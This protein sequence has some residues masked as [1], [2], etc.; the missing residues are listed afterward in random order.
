[1]QNIEYPYKSY[2][3]DTISYNT[4]KIKKKTYTLSNVNYHILN[5]D[6]SVITFDD[7]ISSLY[8]S[9]ILDDD[10]NI[11]CFSPPNSIPFDKFQELN[12][13]VSVFANEIVEGTMINLFYDPRIQSW[14]IATRGAVGGNYW[15]YRTQYKE[16]E[17]QQ[18]TFREMFM[19]ALREPG[20]EL[21]NSPL[22]QNLSKKYCYSFVMQHP[23]NHIVLS[24]QETHLYLVAVY[25]V[26]ERVVKYVPPIYYENWDCFHNSLI[27]F[28]R[29]FENKNYEELRREWCSIQSEYSF[30]GIMFT[31]MYNGYRAAMQ[32]PV[33]E[34]VK[35]LRGNNPNLQYQYFCLARIEQ[36]NRF[37]EFFP[38]YKKLFHQ[39]GKQYQEFI[40]NVHQSYFSYYVKKEGIPISKK[41]FI[42]ASRIHHNIFIP[43]LTETATEEKNEVAKSEKKIITRK[44]VKDYFDAMTPSELLY[45]LNYDKRQMYKDK[46]KKDGVCEVENSSMEM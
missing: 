43:S 10:N 33:Y 39:F 15:F 36:K 27:E 5:N 25:E 22:I 17:G 11:L 28:P 20:G 4:D 2:L 7:T 12:P 19:D 34:D 21:N 37:L 1:M 16:N 9:I 3:V 23:E 45:Y 38:K 13:T 8:R 14:E 6:S 40:T 30:M 24:I 26:H 31:N 32:N 18:K 46:M 41:Y 42:H 35:N 44:V 29:R